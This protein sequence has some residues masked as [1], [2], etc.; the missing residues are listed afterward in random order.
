MCPC[1]RLAP[2]YTVLLCASCPHCSP[3]PGLVVSLLSPCDPSIHP[4]SS[5]PHSPLTVC[6]PLLLSICPGLIVSLLSPAFAVEWDAASTAANRQRLPSETTSAAPEG[7][8]SASETSSSAA[9]LP[10]VEGSTAEAVRQRVSASL[11][12]PASALRCFVVEEV[13]WEAALAGG[14]GGGGVGRHV[15]VLVD[16]SGG[17]IQ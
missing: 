3:N 14:G 16:N 5:V 7:G 12:L 4:F 10:A 6:L 8:L 11:G 1:C 17:E 13:P 9:L 2:P 15:A